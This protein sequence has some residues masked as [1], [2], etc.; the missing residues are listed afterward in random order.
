DSPNEIAVPIEG[1]LFW[2]A[3]GY[4]DAATRAASEASGK[5]VKFV[6]IPN[7]GR[8]GAGIAALGTLI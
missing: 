1:S 8:L 7:A 6:N 2:G 5:T 4:V 3:P